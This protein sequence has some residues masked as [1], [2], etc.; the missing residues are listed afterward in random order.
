LVVGTSGKGIDFSA[1][2]GT[3]TSELLTDYEEGTFDATIST[4]GTNFTSVTYNRQSF[5]YTKIGNVVHFQGNIR[6][7]SVNNTGASGNLLIKGLPFTSSTNSA[8]VNGNSAVVLGLMQAFAT[9]PDAAHVDANSTQISLYASNAALPY[10]GATNG[11]GNANNIYV[12]GA[13]IAA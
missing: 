12:A 3:G 2:P 5:R 1:T 13:Y 11:V 6:T 4:T 10:T 7:S 8:G 9:L